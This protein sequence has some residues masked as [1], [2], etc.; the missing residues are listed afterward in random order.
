[1]GGGMPNK[2]TQFVPDEGVSGGSGF[3][4][5]TR[6]RNVSGSQILHSFLDGRKEREKTKVPV[7]R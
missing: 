3:Q 6:S 7:F 5:N 4:S 1:M 2:K